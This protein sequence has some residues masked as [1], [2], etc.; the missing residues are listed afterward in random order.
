MPLKVYLEIVNTG[1]YRRLLVK[2]YATIEQCYDQWERIVEKHTEA[3]G[4]KGYEIYRDQS[5][6]YGIMVA[7][8]LTEKALLTSLLMKVD[9]GKIEELRNMGYRIKGRTVEEYLATIGKAIKQCNNLM[10]K[11]QVIRNEMIKNATKEDRKESFHEV[12]AAL[13]FMLGF[14]VPETIT[15]AEFNEYRKLIQKKI[16][17]QKESRSGRV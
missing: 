6:R 16:D 2:G 4:N 12:L 3:I 10:T 17:I 9:K 1:N 13:N 8:Y 11:A 15:L 14:T 5:R 7:R